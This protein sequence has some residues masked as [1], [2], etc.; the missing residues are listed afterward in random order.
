MSEECLFLNV[1]APIQGGRTSLR[2]AAAA[3]EGAP[4]AS[5]GTGAGAGNAMQKTLLPVLFW[6][7]G[8]SFT[9]GGSSSYDADAMFE[10]R[11]DAIVV[12]V[13]YR[14]GT[15]LVL[16]TINRTLQLRMV[17]GSLC[18]VTSSVR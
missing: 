6:M 18:C 13:N 5:K 10:V 17:L 11:T 16:H 7:H 14:L 2:A 12:T 3:A 9:M 15:V 4:T 8:G 1:F